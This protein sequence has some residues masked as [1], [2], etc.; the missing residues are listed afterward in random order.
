MTGTD[1]MQEPYMRIQATSPE[2]RV[3]VIVEQGIAI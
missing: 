3:H 1:R 2:K